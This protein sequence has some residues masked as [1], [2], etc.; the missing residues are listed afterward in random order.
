MNLVPVVS[1]RPFVRRTAEPSFE[2]VG[3]WTLEEMRASY[4][5][6]RR[7]LDAPG[8]H[9]LA[10]KKAKEKQEESQRKQEAERQSL[11]K[12]ARETVAQWA[13]ETTRVSS[14]LM[15]TIILVVGA[16]FDVSPLDILSQR[17]FA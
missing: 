15:R 8:L 14:P 1:G 3:P 12:A 7:R 6:A 11:E 17:R 5:G 10:E 16:H 2:Y 9:R 13:S 4:K